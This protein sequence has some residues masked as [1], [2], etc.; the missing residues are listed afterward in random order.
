MPVEEPDPRLCL[1]L[2]PG[3]TQYEDVVL[4]KNDDSLDACRVVP[5]SES[6]AYGLC[7]R[8]AAGW[9]SVGSPRSSS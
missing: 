2:A 6:L 5:R 9:T 1:E 4:Q 7:H 8:V 3:L